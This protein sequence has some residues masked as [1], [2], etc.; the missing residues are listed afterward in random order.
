MKNLL[1][2]GLLLTLPLFVLSCENKNLTGV[3]VNEMYTLKY[4]F[5]SDESYKVALKLSD[6]SIRGFN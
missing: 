6:G 5:F 1:K 3:I 4:G 2:K